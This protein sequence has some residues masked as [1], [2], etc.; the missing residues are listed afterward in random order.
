M[1][2]VGWA[3]LLLGVGVLGGFIARLLWPHQ[4]TASSR[5]SVHALHEQH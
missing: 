1:K 4:P 5:S 3:L 2:F